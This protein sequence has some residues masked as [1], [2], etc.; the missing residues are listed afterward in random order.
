[1]WG[2][3][4]P[5]KPDHALKDVGNTVQEAFRGMGE[6]FK[7]LHKPS[8]FG[9]NSQPS[10]P[11]TKTVGNAPRVSSKAMQGD[12]KG[13]GRAEDDS[14][15]RRHFAALERLV[16]IGLSPQAAR[17]A[18][19]HLDS[20]LVGTAG[21]AEMAAGEA[22]ALASGE[23]I[24]H[25]GDTV[26][27]QGLVKNPTS[28]GQT[29]TLAAYG[30]ENHR[31]KVVMQSNEVFWIKPKLLKPLELRRLSLPGPDAP[32]VSGDESASQSL[33]L[34]SAWAKL[35]AQQQS[36]KEE[37]EAKEIR[38]LE[39]E[40]SLQKYQEALDE[41]QALL[42]RQ[43]QAVK[44]PEQSFR[45]PVPASPKVA[46]FTMQGEVMRKQPSILIREDAPVFADGEIQNDDDDE[47]E[48]GETDEMW[49]LDWASL[50]VSHGPEV[51]G[52]SSP[53]SACGAF[54]GGETKVRLREAR[55]GGREMPKDMDPVAWEELQLKLDEK[56][57][58]ADLHS[59]E[60]HLGERRT[61]FVKGL[62]PGAHPSI[63]PKLQERRRIIEEAETTGLSGLQVPLVRSPRA[64]SKSP[65]EVIELRAT[66]QVHPDIET[67]I[68]MLNAQLSKGDAGNN[69]H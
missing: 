62:L 10:G 9:G 60:D 53:N 6:S 8:W 29:G 17:V 43:L 20:W 55:D 31:W 21:K 56:R 66:N 30:A 3:A 47:E 37:H 39:R 33:S 1:M 63:V 14:S 5:Q 36:W 32:E 59:G 13:E 50:S 52:S 58:L 35:E 28:N 24:L 41:Q 27:L 64:G 42:R 61:E 18:V 2:H 22:S 51:S 69:A 4:Q 19:R 11:P 15:M 7:N 54:K 44:E 65:R 57:R 45:G 48:E 67:R 26:R 34:A 23:P 25:I 12:A 16:E 46:S 49:D 68:D 40:E 38:L